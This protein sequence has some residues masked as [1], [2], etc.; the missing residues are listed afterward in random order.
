MTHSAA[1]LSDRQAASAPGD[2]AR[3]T[4]A[5]EEY[6][7]LLD[8]G[9]RPDRAAFLA[10]YPEIATALSECLAGLEFVHAVAPELSG[11]GRSDKGAAAPGGPDLP[12]LGDF[13]IVREVG[14]GGMG[15]VYEAEQISLNRRVALK[16]L[17]FAATLDDR[18]IQRFKNEAQAAAHLHHTNIVPVHAVGCERGVYYYAMQF[19]D[20]HTLAALIAELRR[21]SGVKAPAEGE[22]TGPYM[23]SPGGGQTAVVAGLSTERSVCSPAFFRRVAELGRQAALALDHAHQMGVIHRDVKPGNLLLDGRGNLWIT[24]FGLAQCQSQASLTMT[25]DLVG[26]LRYMSPEQALAKR[27]IVDHRTDVYSLG[28]TLYELLTLAPAF[29]GQDRQELLR[30]IAFDEPL[31]PRRLN[32]T[33][34]AELETI[35]LKAIEKG[36]A[37][38]YGTA[39][40]LADDLERWLKDEPIRARRPTVV[41]RLRRWSRRHRPVVAALATGLLTVLVVGIVLAFDYQRRLAETDRGVT[42]ALAQAETYLSEGDTQTDHPKQWQDT[43]RLAL[44]ALEKAEELLAAGAATQELLRRVEQVRAAVEAAVTDSCL[45]V[46]LERI[47]LEQS[48]TGK[49]GGFDEA[50]AGPLYAEVLGNYGIDLA[51]PESAAARVRG[52]RLREA[53][54]DALEDWVG[55]TDDAT[56][57]ARVAE[58][59]RRAAPEPDAYSSRWRLAVA[60]RDRAALVQLASAPEVQSLSPAAVVK[61]AG[62]LVRFNE[63]AAAERL[64]RIAQER[65]RSDLWVNHQLGMLLCN[66]KPSRAEE[67]VRYLSVALAL[68]SESPGIHTNLGV[69][70]V[71]MGDVVGAMRCYR[72]AIRLQPKDYRARTNLGMLLA[73]GGKL[74]EAED[75]L[76]QATRL[77]PDYA[78][79]HRGLAYALAE[80]K[81]WPEALAGYREA[82]R[83][84]PKDHLVYNNLGHYLRD[85]GKFAEAERE[86]LKAIKLKADFPAAYYNLGLV[87]GMQG[88][89]ADA[90]AQFRKA[91]ERDPND[92]KARCN[93][94]QALLQQGKFAAALPELRRGHELGSR[95][96]NW[97]DLSASLVREAEF[98]VKLDARLMKVVSGEVAPANADECVQLGWLCQQPYK[99]L[100]VA[101][102]RFYVEA[103]A[104]RPELANDLRLGH[105][106]NAARAAALAGCGKGDRGWR[107]PEQQRL[108]SRQQALAWLRADLQTWR[109]LLE[110]GPDNARP[111]I[112]QRMQHWQKDTDLGGLRGPQALAMLSDA[113]RPAWQQLWAEVAD[114]LA[115]AQQKASPGK[116]P[117]LK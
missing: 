43:T 105:R 77:K 99:Q 54:L 73:E 61:M 34:P 33:I 88:R 62:I 55:A 72:Q 91:V 117:G 22:L 24:D 42:A 4:Q 107:V 25:G 23:P 68:R 50:R 101:A 18:Q 39:Q 84:N 1:R 87:Y 112:I 29:N 80:Q 108:R 93:L 31:A 60:R 66:Q 74:V 69:A 86:L 15:I 46:Q 116:T 57:R 97:P 10:R 70:L 14:R 35:V 37:E 41:Q 75:Q 85:L 79:A 100:N 95:R 27:A 17:P 56:E 38:R 28:A 82:A 21:T 64:L 9:Q 5:L 103:F 89:F 26:T 59:V 71:E 102:A 6:R 110:K 92:P 8:G 94:G 81:K 20:G 67:A 44:A 96:V 30:Q 40:E 78:D 115:R 13:R 65:F 109:R 19:I 49:E 2:E 90:E 111:V 12:P 106:Y 7:A 48:A 63:R 16:V 58:V 113:E 83:I 51:A 47:R 36:P 45:L 114:T 52:S 3:L 104:A 53:L 32:R 76:R 11:E 98:L